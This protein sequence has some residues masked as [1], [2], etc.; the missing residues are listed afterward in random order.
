[1][2]PEVV[3]HVWTW[4][5][6]PF[7]L[8]NSI[9]HAQA[10]CRFGAHCR[11]DAS[12]WYFKLPAHMQEENDYLS[13]A[14]CCVFMSPTCPF[15]ELW[16][17]RSFPTAALQTASAV[18]IRWPAEVSLYESNKV[19]WSN[20]FFKKKKT[21]GCFGVACNYGQKHEIGKTDYNRKGSCLCYLIRKRAVQ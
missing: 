20:F 19:R 4:S 6:G 1:M 18:G 14:H 12:I 2:S 13:L 11:K 8:N 17:W 15:P 7:Q 16:L 10:A 21:C 9:L 5:E 3:W